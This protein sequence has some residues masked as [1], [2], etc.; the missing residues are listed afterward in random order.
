MQEGGD[1]MSAPRK[2]ALVLTGILT[3][4]SVLPAAAAQDPPAAPTAPAPGDKRPR[5]PKASADVPLAGYK[6]GSFYV[7]SPDDSARL[8]L[9]GRLQADQYNYFAAGA[10][11]A[12][13]HST[14]L[15]KRLNIELSGEFKKTWQFSFQ[16]DGG[17]TAL[18]PTTQN[19]AFRVAPSIAYLNFKAAPELNIQI[20]QT[21]A[22]FTFEGRSP[23]KKKVFLENGLPQQLGA[24]SALEIGAMAWGEVEKQVFVYEVGVFSGDG[25]NRLSPDNRVD[26]IGRLWSKPLALGDTALKDAQIGGSIRAGSREQDYVFYDYPGMATQGGFRFWRP[27]YRS[28]DNLVHIIPSG[29]QLGVA[30]ELRIPVDRFDLTGELVYLDNGTREALDTMQSTTTERRGSLSGFASYAQVG[31]WLFGPRDIYGQPGVHRVSTVNLAKPEKPMESALYVVARGEMMRASYSSAARGGAPAARNVDGDINV[32]ALLLG[33]S[34]WPMS[35]VRL[36]ANYCIYDFPDSGPTS[37]DPAD[38]GAAQ[39]SAQRAVA[40]GNTLPVGADSD[41]RSAHTLHEL[42]FRFQIGF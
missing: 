26:V 13:L 18:D 1:G 40:P 30:A 5:A 7:R 15:L 31:V 41:A 36:S 8:Y 32:N 37:A 6:S 17:P 34:Y 24:P 29:N 39:T 11:D 38:P 12:G 42:L 27:T 4:V 25:A 22:P 23:S 10:E 35:L 19:A 2:R 28:A 20:G 14:F 16:I 9:N 3:T 21:L 33:V